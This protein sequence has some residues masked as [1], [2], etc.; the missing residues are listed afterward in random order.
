MA[1]PLSYS[2]EFYNTYQNIENS[3]QSAELAQSQRLFAEVSKNSEEPG[4]RNKVS[5]LKLG[6]V[7]NRLV[8]DQEGNICGSLLSFKTAGN[9]SCGLH[10][11]IGE[12]DE[13]EKCFVC[14]DVNEMREF[15]ALWLENHIEENYLPEGHQNEFKKDFLSTDT[16]PSTLS[17]NPK[18]KDFIARCDETMELPEEERFIATDLL[19]EEFMK[20]PEVNKAYLSH[21]KDSG[22]HLSPEEMHS[23]AIWQEKELHLYTE[24]GDDNLRVPTIYNKGAGINGTVRVVLAKNHYERALFTP[25]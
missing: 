14:P 5:D 11:L 2:D 18:V 17:S 19:L 10:A 12:Y 22:S 21:I 20:D 15:F 7:R 1:T 8:I 16:M 23:A 9:G 24:S 25:T 13:K 3:H 6:R 4:L